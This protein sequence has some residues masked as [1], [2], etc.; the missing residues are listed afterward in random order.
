MR[1]KK[2]WMIPVLAVGMAMCVV[3]AGCP[4]GAYH[5]SVVAEHSFTTALKSFQDAEKA[6]SQNGRIDAAEHRTLEAG[7]GKIGAS[8]QVLVASLQSGA[9]NTTVQQNFQTVID[10]IGDLMNNGVLGIKNANS[11]ALLKGSLAVVQDVLK[12][13]ATLAA[14][15][16]ATP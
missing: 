13:A 7:I 11:Q 4:K 12:N 15:G 5:D 8:A 9:A 3:A 16:T 2:L 1:I 14:G 10:A 6:E